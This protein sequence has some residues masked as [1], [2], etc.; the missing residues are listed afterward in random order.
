MYTHL[1]VLNSDLQ[2]RSNKFHYEH[3]SIIWSHLS[4]NSQ[5]FYIGINV[6]FT[7]EG[8]GLHCDRPDTWKP[9]NAFK[10]LCMEQLNFRNIAFRRNAK[11]KDVRCDFQRLKDK[12]DADTDMVLVFISTH[13]SGCNYQGCI[14]L[15]DEPEFDIQRE[16][17]DLRHAMD[18][19]SATNGTTKI[20][21]LVFSQV[22]NFSMC[23][24]SFKIKTDFFSKTK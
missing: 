12:L 16:L 15:H 3:I 23:L 14:V 5:F 10:N 2:E 1:Q 19:V 13:A 9:A 21:L 4:I 20:P 17:K 24:P 8:L 22:K 11:E 7:R 18:H 6:E